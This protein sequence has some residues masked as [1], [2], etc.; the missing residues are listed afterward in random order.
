MAMVVA[1][2]MQGMHVCSAEPVYMAFTVLV[3]SDGPL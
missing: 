2:N 3:I 1:L